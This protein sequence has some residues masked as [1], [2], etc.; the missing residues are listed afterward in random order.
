MNLLPKNILILVLLSLSSSLLGLEAASISITNPSG[1]ING[2]EISMNGSSSEANAFVSIY[3]NGNYLGYVTTNG[4]GN[5]SYTMAGVTQNGNYTLEVS[6]LN[7][8]LNVLATSS[9]TF[10]VSNSNSINITSPTPNQILVSNPVT[11]S[12]IASLP[13]AT[14]N[15]SLDGSLVTTATT[16]GEGNWE[17]SYTLNAAPGTRTFLAQ[18]LLS[19]SPTASASVNITNNI[20]LVF[21]QGISQNRLIAGNISVPT[22]ASG[23]GPGYTYSISGSTVTI[24]FV[25]SFSVVPT[26]TATGFRNSGSSTITISAISSSSV[27]LVFSTSTQRIY[28][29]ASA[30]Q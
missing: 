16:D 23:S 9:R 18:L 6:L 17:R 10:T 11:L 19:G 1:T 21:P 15:I 25:P 29:S 2:N 12:G 24:S 28:F 3:L 22:P 27:S 5:W 13:F 7:R 4:I 20:P 26:V 30:L 8:D 14:V